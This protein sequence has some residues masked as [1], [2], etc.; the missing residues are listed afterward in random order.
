MGLLWSFGGIL[1]V[2]AALIIILKRDWWP[3]VAIAAIVIS[4][5]L[6]LSHWHEAKFGTMANAIILISAIVGFGMR[7]FEM[8][9]I[10]MTD[11]R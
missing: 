7:N 9:I 11:R 5:T 4:Q 8:V 2:V 1:F 3:T 10:L 6:I